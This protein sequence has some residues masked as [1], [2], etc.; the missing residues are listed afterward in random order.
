M[1]LFRHGLVF[2]TVLLIVCIAGPPNGALAEPSLLIHNMD[3]ECKVT[4]RFAHTTIVAEIENQLNSSHE[5]VFDVELPKTAFITNFSMTI[6]GITTVGVVKKKAE[7]D[8]QYERAIS[9][10]QN[11]GL[12]Q[13]IGRK[14][15]NFK[16]SVNVRARATAIFKLTYEELLKRHQGIYQLQL[17]VEPKQLVENFQITVDIVEP[18][19]ISFVNAFGG[20]LTNELMDTVQIDHNQNKAHIVFKPT[21]EQQRKCPGC[22]ETLLDGDFVIKY[23]V[24][25]EMSAGN[26]QI[27]N[28]HFV[29]Y[30]APSILDRVPKNVVFVIDCSLSMRGRKIK[31]TYEAFIK[32]LSDLPEEDHFGILKFSSNV[33]KWNDALLKATP[34][35]IQSAMK[36][37][38]KIKAKG[39]TD[40]NSALLSAIKM[41]KD[42]REAEIFP[43]ISASSIIFLSDGDP[44]LGETN[45]AT[46]MKNVQQAA[47]GVA[48]LYSLGF[49]A[50]VDYSFLEKM[51]LGNGGLARRIYLD[52]DSALQLQDFYKEV[53]NPVLLDVN[54]RY[55]N[56]PV[57]D[58]TQNSFKYYYQGSEIV[59]AGQIDSNNVDI[60]IAEVAA[61]G[62]TDPFSMRVET[63]IR[64]DV[65]VGAE[66][67]YIFGDFTERLWAYL[68]IDQLLTKRISA[69]GEL[70]KNFT[71]KALDLSLKYNFVTPL[72][73]LVITKLEE[74]DDSIT[75]VA[76]KPKEDNVPAVS[77]P[78][79]GA[80]SQ[81]IRTAA[82]LKTRKPVRLD[83]LSFPV[84]ISAAALPE[85]MCLGFSEPPG[86][87]VNLFHNSDRGITLNGKLAA[88]NNGFDKLGLVHKKKMVS[89]EITAENITVTKGRDT[90]VYPWTA[91]AQ[92]L[93]VV[94]KEVDTLVASLEPGLKVIISLVKHLDLLKLQVESKRRDSNYTIGLVSHVTS[95][96]NITVTFGD[97]S[98]HGKSF[99]SSRSC[100]CDVTSFGV[101]N[102]GCCVTFTS[103]DLTAEANNIVENIFDI[104][105]A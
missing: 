81:Y 61:Q 11:A 38:S 43:E 75:M 41:L 100:S 49:G 65:E 24:N 58:L 91:V 69:G 93:W 46:I 13:S 1:E 17:K 18:Q 53:A 101:K 7:A 23:D 34:D 77:S 25:R 19:G 74:S 57:N 94:K 6:D 50:D 73:S 80:M 63:D 40:I 29:H 103:D 88:D 90:Q 47:D 79:F 37:V 105:P 62:M 9:K 35:N 96:N 70:N 84:L 71:E 14:M 51:S 56:L 36:F 32:I 85:K 83:C 98:I 72:T 31:Q 28:G 42:G 54:L 66:Q 78:S 67:K 39:G 21:L 2:T 3:I 95:D 33:V 92:T 30:F 104:P 12:V 60:L 8:E 15:E 86:G 87:I 64:N 59:V 10:G 4:S 22:T 26:I 102:Q 45:I 55:L 89:I 52:S 44:T 48:T 5:A 16:I 68:T 99:P 76:K 82:R 20:F 27:V 97:I